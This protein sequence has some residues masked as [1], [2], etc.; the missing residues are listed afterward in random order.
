MLM[1]LFKVLNNADPTI[2]DYF[3]HWV[4]ERHSV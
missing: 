2:T 1:D 4:T 3:A